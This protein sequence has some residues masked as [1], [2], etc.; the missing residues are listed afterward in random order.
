[1]QTSAFAS[2]I[3]GNVGFVPTRTIQLQS[4][5]ASVASKT[6]NITIRVRKNS[7]T[8]QEFV[9]SGDS[10]SITGD[11]SSNTFTTSDTVFMDIIAGAG[12]DLAVKFNY[13]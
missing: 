9:I 7:S 12:V 8:L 10:L 2:T 1:V 5:E 3:T 6:S 4:I 11:F 13:K